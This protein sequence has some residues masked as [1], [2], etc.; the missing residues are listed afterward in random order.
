MIKDDKNIENN[1]G[2]M[3]SNIELFLDNEFLNMLDSYNKCL[4][5]KVK[6]EIINITLSHNQNRFNESK[7]SYNLKISVQY[8]PVHPSDRCHTR[9]TFF[10]YSY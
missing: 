5:I 8:F 4:Y 2:N 6:K 7:E 1:F 10:L 9:P 3:L